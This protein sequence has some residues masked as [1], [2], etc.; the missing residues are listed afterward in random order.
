MC[1]KS[2]V[3]ACHMNE[4]GGGIAWLVGGWVDARTDEYVDSRVGV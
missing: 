4:V 2:S 3:T 1:G